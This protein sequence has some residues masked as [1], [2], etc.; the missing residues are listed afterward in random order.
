VLA[1]VTSGAWLVL[2]A[3]VIGALPM[4][5]AGAEHAPVEAHWED[6]SGTDCPSSL[7]PSTCQ[8][9]LVLTPRRDLPRAASAILA[10]LATVEDDAPDAVGVGPRTPA[11]AGT[12]SRGP[13][14][15]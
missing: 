4:A 2:Y 10:A 7:D 6:A 14:I 11:R 15:G 12:S 1:R 3:L 8:L 13:P 5:D 9:C